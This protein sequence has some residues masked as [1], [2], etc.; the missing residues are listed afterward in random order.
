MKLTN[1]E[2]FNSKVPLQQLSAL[3]FPV[4]TSLALVKLTIKLNELRAPIQQVHDGLIRTYGEEK[5]GGRPGQTAISP[6]DKNWEKFLAEFQALMTQ[7]AE[8]VIDIVALPDTLEIEP[9]ILMPLEKFIK[10]E[11]KK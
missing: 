4:L 3:K 9:A 11:S 7:E 10:V 1:L 6:G 2:I 8:R 5:E